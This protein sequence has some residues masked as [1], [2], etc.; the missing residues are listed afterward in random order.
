M[1]HSVNFSDR[2]YFKATAQFA[3][4]ILYRRHR[5]RPA[6]PAKTCSR[7]PSAGVTI[8]NHF[9]G[10]ILVGVSPIYFRNF[11]RE[12]FGGDTDYSASLIRDDGTLLASYPETVRQARNRYAMQLWLMQSRQRLRPG[13]STGTRAT[14][15]TDRLIAYR[16]LA[17]YP[18]YVTVGRRWDSIVREWRDLMATHLI[19][20]IPAT[21]GLLALSLLARRQARR[22]NAILAQAAGRSSPARTWPRRRCASRRRWKR[23]AA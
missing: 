1:D 22:Q 23:S 21:L 10:V 6:H 8:P 20:G 15:G 2:E 3:F 11:D 16:K 17:K 18:V 5:I 9:A 19:F 12:M 7:S 14:D 4:A 13:W